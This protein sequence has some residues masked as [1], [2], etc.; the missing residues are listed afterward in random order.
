MESVKVSFLGQ[1]RTALKTEYTMEGVPYYTLQLFDF[2]LGQYS[3]T[4]TLA[5][6]VEDNTADLL[7]LFYAVE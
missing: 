3:I 7:D 6:F 2:D 4:L 5:S 1:E